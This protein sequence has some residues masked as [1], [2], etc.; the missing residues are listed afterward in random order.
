M[1]QKLGFALLGIYV[2]SVVLANYLT[3]HFGLVDIG[4]GLLTTA[5]TIA[6][7]G[8]IMTRDLLQDALGRYAVLGAILAGALISWWLSSPQLAFASGATFLLA[9]GL[10]FLVYTPLRRRVGFATGKWGG[11]VGI[12][13]VTGAIVDTLLFL[14]LAGFPITKDVVLGQLVGKAYIT[15]AVVGVLLLT[16]RAVPRLVSQS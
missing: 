14:N 7:G 11:I 16:R 1:R 13:N 3:A 15:L 10:E 8:A 5:G 9:E 12:A 4:F 2:G 6:I